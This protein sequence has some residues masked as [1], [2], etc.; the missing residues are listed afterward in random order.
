LR[1]SGLKVTAGHRVQTG[2]VENP[3]S[4]WVLTLS[5]GE[6][7]IAI[8][9]EAYA[10]LHKYCAYR[11]RNQ[12]LLLTLR[13]RCVQF[14]RE[15]GMSDLLASWVVPG[16]VALA[17]HVLPLEAE[18]MEFTAGP[19]GVRSVGSDE[20]VRKAKVPDV[21]DVRTAS[22]SVVKI[23]QD[24]WMSRFVSLCAGTRTLRPGRSL[25]RGTA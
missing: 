10:A 3:T 24:G 17:M 18:A 16:T 14:L 15:S 1:S 12:E 8:S 25:P 2:T 11:P 13:T 21:V 22:G 7:E 20:M 5:Q 9:L 6:R 19:L 23:V 4:D